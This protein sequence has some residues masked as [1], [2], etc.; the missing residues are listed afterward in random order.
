MAKYWFKMDNAFT[1]NPKVLRVGPSAGYLWIASIA[2]CARNQTDGILPKQQVKLLV[3]WQDSV[4]PF[5]LAELLVSERLWIDAENSYEVH[6]YLDWQQSA[7]EIN[8]LS[9]YR[10]NAGKTSGKIRR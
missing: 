5:L 6:D 4:S 1:D 8:R 7:S 3:D 9:K 10:S 2:W